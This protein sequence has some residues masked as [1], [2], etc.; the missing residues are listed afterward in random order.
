MV[1]FVLHLH[2]IA[3]TFLELNLWSPGANFIPIS[4]R[5]YAYKK[6]DYILKSMGAIPFGCTRETNNA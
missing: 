2:G 4:K 1:H 5:I 6:I 3:P